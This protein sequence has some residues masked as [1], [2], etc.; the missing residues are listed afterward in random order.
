MISE[1]WKLETKD[2]LLA[3]KFLSSIWKAR[4]DKRPLLLTDAIAPLFFCDRRGYDRVNNS[5][6]GPGTTSFLCPIGIKMMW[7]IID[8]RK[9]SKIKS[10]KIRND[11]AWLYALQKRYQTYKP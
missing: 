9:V 4:N 7:G 2:V 1:N 11:M 8:F 10:N 5:I 3:L 6:A